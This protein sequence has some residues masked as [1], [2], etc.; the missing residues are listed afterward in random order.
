M[1]T[2][3]VSAKKTEPSRMSDKDTDQVCTAGEQRLDHS[4]PTQDQAQYLLSNLDAICS[5]DG[6]TVVR[7]ANRQARWEP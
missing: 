3:T 7:G 1:A 6:A 2:P 4:H 5:Y